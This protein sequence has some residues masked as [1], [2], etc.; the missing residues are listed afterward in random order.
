MNFNASMNYQYRLFH[1]TLHNTSKEKNKD[2]K[3][4]DNYGTATVTFSEKDPTDILPNEV[5]PDGAGG[6]DT[7]ATSETTGTAVD[8]SLYKVPIEIRMPD[9]SLG[10]ETDE[11]HNFV[12]EWYK[13]PGDVINKNDILC[14][15]TTPDFTFGMVTDDDETA[16]MGE[17]HV[18][19]GEKVPDHTPICTIYHYGD[20]PPQE[21]EDKKK[22]KNN[23]N[24][25]G[26]E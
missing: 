17:I 16:I 4:P 1:N 21:E 11:K 20:A 18:P 12:D 7:P 22:K 3:E 6:D 9:M 13:Q 19:P 10:E 24:D 8:K 14:D 15:I 5:R 2:E 25:D 26:D 23:T